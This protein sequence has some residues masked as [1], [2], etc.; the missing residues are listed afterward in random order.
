MQLYRLSCFARINRTCALETHRPQ[1]L[2]VAGRR[3]QSTLVSS[4]Y[5]AAAPCQ[6]GKSN[7]PLEVALSSC[8]S[9]KFPW[10]QIPSGFCVFR[11]SATSLRGL[12]PSARIL[13]A[14][15]CPHEQEHRQFL[16]TPTNMTPVT[17]FREHIYQRCCLADAQRPQQACRWRHRP[18]GE[19]GEHSPYMKTAPPSQP[20][21]QSVNP[22]RCRMDR[23]L[24][25]Q[26]CSGGRQAGL[27]RHRTVC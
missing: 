17:G 14:P 3:F 6:S 7:R 27:L 16:Q 20:L 9:Q 5:L 22:L 11:H 26:A 25:V 23:S 8:L 21:R 4:R 24:H 10:P 13:R 2:S 1:L 15:L 19:E 18:R 12:P